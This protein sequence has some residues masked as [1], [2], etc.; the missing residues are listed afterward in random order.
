MRGTDLGGDVGHLHVL[1]LDRVVALAVFG[2]F[3]ACVLGLRLRLRLG[4]GW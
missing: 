4:L 3:L 2:G 1:D